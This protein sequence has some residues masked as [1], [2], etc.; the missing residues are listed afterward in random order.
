MLEFRLTG[1]RGDNPLGFLTSLGTLVTLEDAG[2]SASL[3]WDGLTPTLSVRP[4][5]QPNR[6]PDDE[7]ER[8]TLLIAVLHKEL[9]RE[10]GAEAAYTQQA[11]K[12]MEQAKKS[13][14]KKLEEIKRRKLDRQARRNELAPLDAEVDAK[15]A[16]FKQSLAKSAADPCVMLGKNLTEPNAALIQHLSAAC[17]RCSPADRRWVDIAAAYGLADPTRPEERMWPS[18]WALVSGSGHQNFLTTVEDLMVLCEASHLH[19]ALF[20]PWEPRDKKYS[21]RLDTADDRRYALMDRDPTDEGNKPHTLWGAN[22]LAFEALRLFPAIPVGGGMG[23]RSW[24]TAKQNW[25]EGCRIRWPLWRPPSGIAAIQ[26]LLGL[27]DLWVDD[28][29]ARDRLRGIGVHAVMESR[30]IAVGQ[31]TNRKFNLTPP[32]PVWFSNPEDP[33]GHQ[34]QAY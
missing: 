8:R 11:K 20:G 2:R 32:T 1:P 9:R 27:R 17:E 12:E 29:V 26:S 14:K 28:S 16:A 13:R 19:Q 34:D 5:L 4:D 25:Q 31:G 33:M 3:G 23:V 18:P 22:R 15:V 7:E 6:P 21:L 10:R 24:R 30:R